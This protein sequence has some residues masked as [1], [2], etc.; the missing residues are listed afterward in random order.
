MLSPSINPQTPW[1]GGGPLE[2]T[3]GWTLWERS[4]GGVVPTPHP[5][6]QQNPGGPHNTEPTRRKRGAKPQ[7][8]NTAG[9]T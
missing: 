4:G 9:D 5:T 2:K 6:P 7:T 3:Q 1:T 8:G